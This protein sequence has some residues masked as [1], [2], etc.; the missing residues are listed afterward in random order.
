M[1]F[2]RAFLGAGA[3]GLL[4]S[5]WPVADASTEMLMGRFYERLKVS[6][7]ALALQDAQLRLIKDPRYNH[8]FFWAPFDFVGA[9]TRAGT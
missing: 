1:G 3:R 2:T 5:L 9:Y 6:D 4:V 7:A 8:P